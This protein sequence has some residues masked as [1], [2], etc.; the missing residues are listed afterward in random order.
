MRYDFRSGHRHTSSFM[1]SILL[2]RVDLE[3]HLQSVNPLPANLRELL[4]CMPCPSPRCRKPLSHG[5]LQN[6]LPAETL[7][8]ASPPPCCSGIL[9]DCS[10]HRGPYSV[11]TQRPPQE[12]NQFA[13]YAAG[14][15][16]M[17]SSATG[18]SNAGTTRSR[19][20]ARACRPAHHLP[21]LPGPP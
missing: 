19:A 12:R 15:K 8:K 2:R 3:A 7:E 11:A 21:H 20:P 9:A 14:Q 17:F 16:H 6:L 13:V 1:S 4:G 10:A 5:D 18:S